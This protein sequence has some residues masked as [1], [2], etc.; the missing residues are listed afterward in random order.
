[1]RLEDGFGGF[2]EVEPGWFDRAA[3]RGAGW[4]RWFPEAEPGQPVDYS[5][6][7]A[8]CEGCP[9]R[10]R[11]LDYAQATRAAE[12]VWGGLTPSERRRLRKVQRRAA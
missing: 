8:V 9:V 10:A 11:C 6:A 5:A 12:G 1:V 4:D 7:V 2:G 3:C